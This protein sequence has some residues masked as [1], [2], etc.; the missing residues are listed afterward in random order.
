MRWFFRLLN[1]DSVT[2]HLSA[3]PQILLLEVRVLLR[4]ARFTAH[5]V[6]AEPG[7]MAVLSD[8]ECRAT[9][10]AR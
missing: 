9:S 10:D 1:K 7:V 3:Q 6:L 8:P 2:E 4:L 5:A